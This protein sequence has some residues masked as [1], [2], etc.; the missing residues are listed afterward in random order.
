[1]AGREPS[2]GLFVTKSSSGFA[3]LRKRDE[4]ATRRLPRNAAAGRRAS[5]TSMLDF[6]ATE[7]FA[8]H[9]CLMGRRELPGVTLG[10]L[11]QEGEARRGLSDQGDAW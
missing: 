4:K 9:G 5:K 8:L 1:V 11:P 2:G 7:L 6:T 3:L 10:T